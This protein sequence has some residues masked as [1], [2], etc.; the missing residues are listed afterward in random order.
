MNGIP[1]MATM[2]QSDNSAC[3]E[4][5][6]KDCKKTI[7]SEYCDMLCSVWDNCTKQGYD[8]CISDCK[9]HQ[10]ECDESAKM[11]NTTVK[12][13]CALGRPTGSANS[14]VIIVAIVVPV[15]VVVIAVVVVAIICYC[16]HLLCFAKSG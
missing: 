13:I 8:T 14:A 11:F 4:A 10:S 2:P 12:K 9:K 6:A 15:V 16:K 7:K 5:C 3:T 1:S